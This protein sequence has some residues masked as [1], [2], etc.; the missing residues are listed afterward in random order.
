[1]LYKNYFLRYNNK[2]LKWHPKTQRRG[3]DPPTAC[4]HQKRKD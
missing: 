2:K 1:M 3:L 4:E